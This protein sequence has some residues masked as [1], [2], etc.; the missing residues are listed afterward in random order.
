MDV[1]LSNNKQSQ[2]TNDQSKVKVR[3]KPMPPSPQTKKNNKPATNIKNTKPIEQKPIKK[4]SSNTNFI[5]SSVN[6]LFFRPITAPKETVITPKKTTTTT[7]IP[8]KPVKTSIA[9][10][11]TN[12]N[13]SE[14]QSVR[15][16]SSTSAPTKPIEKKSSDI[17]NSTGTTKK[18]TETPSAKPPPVTLGK[19]PKLN[20]ANKQKP[21]EIPTPS[22]SLTDQKLD[23]LAVSGGLSNNKETTISE[24]NLPKSRSPP[25]SNRPQQNLLE[26]SDPFAPLSPMDL[27]DSTDNSLGKPPSTRYP[28]LLD[29]N[30]RLTTNFSRTN[31]IGLE[32]TQSQSPLSPVTN[33]CRKTES[34]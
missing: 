20:P 29:T 30:P 15:L 14:K 9:K 3:L 13:N 12:T 23:L 18:P 33:I 22:K 10:P 2:N 4:Y 25:R 5:L 31:S 27:V 26:N 1:T 17:S 34:L 6:F 11:S 24:K 7:I 21:M 19:I 16:P 8:K 28:S 32:N